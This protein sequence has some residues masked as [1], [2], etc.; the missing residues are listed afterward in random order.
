MGGEGGMARLRPAE[1][2]S[3]ER[4]IAQAALT[5]E[6]ATAVTGAEAFFGVMRAISIRLC[7]QGERGAL[8]PLMRRR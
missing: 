6:Y 1:Y 4:A 8:D 7:I 5:P 2:R 3:L